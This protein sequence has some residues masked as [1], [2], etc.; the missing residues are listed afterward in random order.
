MCIRDSTSQL[1]TKLVAH[2]S[3]TGKHLDYLLFKIKI[4]SKRVPNLFYNA[5]K[6]SPSQLLKKNIRELKVYEVLVDYGMLV[7]AEDIACAVDMLPNSKL[8]LMKLLVAK[9]KDTDGPAYD[10]AIEAATK[11]NKKQFIAALKGGTNRVNPSPLST[12]YK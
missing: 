6:V 2:E 8:Q 9:C 3:S 4:D 12:V 5:S 10:K 1:L 11:S 7:T